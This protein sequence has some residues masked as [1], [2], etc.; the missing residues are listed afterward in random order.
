MN[1][2]SLSFII[3]DVEI[4]KT[5][6]AWLVC[7]NGD[8]Q[9]LQILTGFHREKM[10]KCLDIIKGHKMVYEPGVVDENVKKYAELFINLKL[11]KMGVPVKSS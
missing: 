5:L 9:E 4:L 6:A 11:K 10:I 1:K 7:K 2:L 3:D 8:V